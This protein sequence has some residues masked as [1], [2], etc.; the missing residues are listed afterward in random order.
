MC[1]RVCQVGGMRVCQV[2][3]V[4]VCVSGRCCACVSVCQVGGTKHMIVLPVL[5]YVSDR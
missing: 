3:G 2:G 1:V 5:L 4:C